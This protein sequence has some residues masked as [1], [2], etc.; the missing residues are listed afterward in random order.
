[1]PI[2]F[3][4]I[5]AGILAIVYSLDKLPNNEWPIWATVSIVAVDIGLGLLGSAL[6][7][8]VK[9]DLIRRER[10]RHRSTDQEED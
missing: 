10:L 6:I 9:S 8:K 1:M 4:F 5:S 7:H 2:G 3:L